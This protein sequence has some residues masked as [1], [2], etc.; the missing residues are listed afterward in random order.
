MGFDHDQ[1][2]TGRKIRV[3]TIVGTFARFS[4]AIEPRFGFR[5]ADVVEVL[6]RVGREHGLPGAIR[7]DRGTESVPRDLD[8]WATSAGSRST[9]P[10]RGSRPTTPASRA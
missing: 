8:P 2:A 7:V 9:S 4:P 10:G 5:A 1:L 6:E 3:L